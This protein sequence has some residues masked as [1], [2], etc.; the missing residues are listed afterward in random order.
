MPIS[1]DL[2]SVQTMLNTLDAAEH[3]GLL[4][5][6]CDNLEALADQVEALEGVPLAPWPN[7]GL[8]IGA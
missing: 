4:C 5:L 8:Y 7:D 6:L 3:A 1:E 2:R